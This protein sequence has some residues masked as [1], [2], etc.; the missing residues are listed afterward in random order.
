VTEH[1]HH[2]RLTKKQLKQDRFLEAVYQAWG[3]AQDN[4]AV[5]I[6][7]V[8]AL[9]A[10][11]A[12]GVRV[13]GTVS[14]P[15]GDPE[16]ERALSDARMLFLAGQ[17]DA[18]VAALEEVRKRHGGSAV[19][20]EATL[21]LAN[22]LYE[23]GQF[24]PALAVFQEY[25]RKPLHDDLTRDHARVA[26]ASCREEM[27]DL[28]GAQQAY[29]EIWTTAANP[30]LRVQGAMAAARCA[31]AQSQADREAGF[32]R[33]VVETYPD[34]PEAELARFRLLEIEGATTS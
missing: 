21:L 22:S 13:G 1:H 17:P 34:C 4:V 11:V 6:G 32:Y 24:E 7:G 33:S 10:L 15:K 19:G 30:A 31:R 16:A 29:E 3:Y 5:V 28:A 9:I 2:R 27:G 23:S 26:I 18:G 8:I 12:L 14:G 25:L 20:R